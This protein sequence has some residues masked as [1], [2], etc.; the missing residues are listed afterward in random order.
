MGKINRCWR[1]VATALCFSIF[2]LGGLALSLLVLPTINLFVRDLEKRQE[3]AQR[4]IRRSFRV[5]VA[6]M[7]GLGVMDL[8][9]EGVDAL[10][11]ESGCIVVANHPTLIDYVLLAALLPRCVCIVKHAMWRNPFV[12]GVIAAAGYLDNT[13]PE[14]MLARCAAVLQSGN[15]LL[16]FPEGTR[17]VPG[18]KIQLKRG[19][20]QVAVRTRS[21]MRVVWISCTP[22]YLHKQE[23]WLRVPQQ[24]PFFLVRTMEKVKIQGF[25]EEAPSEAAAARRVTDYLSGVLLGEAVRQESS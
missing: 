8:Q 17:T 10:E 21:D 3:T 9:V 6:L 23:S 18:G 24:K 4:V 12:K 19:A 15:I 11:R 5:F 20:A 2:G 1:F 7:K 16:V 25:I 22:P 13:D 14:A